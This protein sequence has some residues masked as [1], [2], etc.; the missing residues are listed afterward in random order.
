K[1]ADEVITTVYLIPA[2]ACN[3]RCQYC[4]FVQE[5]DDN[6]NYARMTVAQA[7]QLVDAYYEMAAAAPPR[8]REVVFFGGEPFM[9]PD[10][11]HEVLR[12]IREDRGDL[13][14]NLTAITNGSLISDEIAAAC[15]RYGLYAIVSVDGPPEVNDRARVDLHG[16]PSFERTVKGYRTLKRAGC[17]MGLSLMA[18]R[19]NVDCLEESVRWLLDELEPDEISVVGVFHPLKNGR[20]PFQADPERTVKAMIDTYVACRER[21]VY[22][23]QV[24][25]RLRPFVSMRPKLKDCMACGG[26]VIAT[27]MG[28]QGSCEYLAYLKTSPHGQL[29]QI[30]IEGDEP[31]QWKRRSPVNMLDCQKCPALGVCGGGC[32]YNA[33]Q[34][35]GS[36]DGLDENNCEQTRLL[37]GWMLEDLFRVCERNGELRADRVIFPTL[38][39]RQ[40]LFGAIDAEDP[41]LPM[42]AVSRHGEGGQFGGSPRPA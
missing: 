18:G 15:A 17:K 4:E 7:R 31:E 40:A 22:V 33:Y 36:L 26:K 13:D 11:I 21:G 1:A 29:V 6:R 16:G 3:Y 34:L 2:M 25:R 8:A 41:S 23:D 42:K 37:L 9:A 5:F 27:P 30:Q 10:I 14:I 28:M 24:A 20:N 12:Y 35:T 38:A 39:E 32:H 19:H